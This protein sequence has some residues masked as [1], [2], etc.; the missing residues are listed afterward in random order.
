MAVLPLSFIAQEVCIQALL[1]HSNEATA[2]VSLYVRRLFDTDKYTA[3]SEEILKRIVDLYPKS[4]TNEL[5]VSLVPPHVKELVLRDCTNVGVQGMINVCKKCKKLVS[6]DLTRCDQLMAPCLFKLLGRI[7]KTITSLSLEEC[8]KITDITVQTILR[9]MQN[10]RSLSL[11]SCVGIT[12]DVFLLNTDSQI[13]TDKKSAMPVFKPDLHCAHLTSL[14]V[15]GCQSITSNAI[16][17]LT[18]LC[19][20]SLRHVDISW[21]KIDILALWYLAGYNLSSAMDLRLNIK[22]L[23]GNHEEILEQI[24]RIN[25]DKSPQS[26]T[27][28]KEK[29]SQLEKNWVAMETLIPEKT[30][31]NYNIGEADR[32]DGENIGT[33]EVEGVVT[34]SKTGEFNSLKDLASETEEI[35]FEVTSG[36]FDF[37]PAF[38]APDGWSD[39]TPRAGLGPESSINYVM[40]T[41][42]DD[43]KNLPNAAEARNF[44]VNFDDAK[45]TVLVNNYTSH[46]LGDTGANFVRPKELV[47]M[48]ACGLLAADSKETDRTNKS[49]ETKGEE[50]IELELTNENVEN[51]GE[52]VKAML[53]EASNQNFELGHK[54]LADK[55]EVDDISNCDRFVE[56]ATSE[57]GVAGSSK[58]VDLTSVWRDS[59]NLDPKKSTNLLSYEE[60]AGFSL[61]GSAELGCYV[62]SENKDIPEPGKSGGRAMPKDEELDEKRS[63]KCDSSVSSPMSDDQ[64]AG[65]NK[66]IE[67]GSLLQGN[68]SQEVVQFYKPDISVMKIN[69]MEKPWS[70]EL[71]VACMKAF[72]SKNSHVTQICITWKGM[73]DELLEFIVE[74]VP[75][76]TH[77]KLTD[78]ESLSLLG[79][80][81]MSLYC[82]KIQHLDLKGV[83]FIGDAAVVPIIANRSLQTLSVAEC[84]ISDLTLR[85][86]SVHCHEKLQSLD[87]SWCENLTTDGIN[88]VAKMC[89][90]L[91]KLELR[92][93]AVTDKTLELLGSQ[94]PLL[95]KLNLSNVD[96]TDDGVIRLAQRLSLLKNL[97]ISWNQALTDD[98]VDA[99][100]TNCP[101][102]DSLCLVG[103]K[104]LTSKPFLPIIANFNQ[105][106]RCQALLHLKQRE[107]ELFNSEEHYS[108]DEE[109][110]DL[111]VPHRSTSYSPNLT[112]LNLDYC[113]QI[114]DTHLG[115]IVAVCRGSLAISDYYGC[116]V[117]AIWATAKPE[118][119]E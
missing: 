9:H 15:S 52:E 26:D 36:A 41:E 98:S 83:C 32:F 109:F 72:F 38:T 20:P 45:M 77:V 107:R 37:N 55:L 50:V 8:T 86:L 81:K 4:L 17:H 29:R 79:L 25:L 7:G 21:T 84:N 28:E 100:L 48:V 68:I 35:E 51:K 5:L 93:C 70:Y 57:G 2:T 11:S 76:V 31:E 117:A 90:L 95:E 113:D 91:K 18:T 111:Y 87:L 3:V 33:Y 23:H 101:L 62:G 102:M 116:S 112:E 43:S 30:V 108:S 27:E 119:L 69:F 89:T 19:G 56:G 103:L 22:D 63:L 88:L 42:C 114:N 44:D 64:S 73:N 82:K 96:I 115:N 6:L 85:M 74:R 75:D 59:L 16:R 60:L 12:D 13:V 47:N 46:P 14:D 67:T 97:D 54:S 58:S 105:W 106:Q 110:E 94:C 1:G 39:D 53:S 66:L 118:I 34:T 40:D 71:G 80:V 24:K 99:I 65:G 104:R 10:L 61:A 92:Q 49:A 78:C